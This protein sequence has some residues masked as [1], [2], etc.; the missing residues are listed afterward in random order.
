M[1]AIG[2]K[3]GKQGNSTRFDV[4]RSAI[5]AW[6]VFCLM[7]TIHCVGVGDSAGKTIAQQELLDRMASGEA[8]LLLD[9]RSERE[10]AEGHL[11]GAMLIPHD[12]LKTRVAELAAYKDQE[13]VVYCRSG[14]RASTAEAVLREA[15]FT[16]I[17]DL[18]GHILLWKKNGYPLEESLAPDRDSR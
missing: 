1:R 15:G 9:V 14:A 5:L 4:V 16:K 17:R 11:R 18:D 2:C 7:L 13:I 3:Y 8:P 6:G 12:E 10:Y